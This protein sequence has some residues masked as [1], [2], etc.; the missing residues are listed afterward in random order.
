M[1]VEFDYLN[2]IKQ[3]KKVIPH[4]DYLE[5]VKPSFNREKEI[6]NILKED[7][8]KKEL[9]NTKKKKFTSELYELDKILEPYREPYCTDESALGQAVKTGK[10]VL[11]KVQG[12]TSDIKVTIIK[13]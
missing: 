11:P 4:K 6:Q 1:I 3:I 2:G 13:K 10:L 7:K 9:S 5:I 8:R 12:G